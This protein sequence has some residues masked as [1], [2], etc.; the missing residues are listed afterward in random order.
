MM[1][2]RKGKK[3]EPPPQPEAAPLSKDEVKEKLRKRW[4]EWAEEIG[5]EHLSYGHVL[6]GTKIDSKSLYT[7][8]EGIEAYINGLRTDENGAYVKDFEDDIDWSTLSGLIDEA[9]SGSTP[10]LNL[11]FKVWKEEL[12]E[13][14]DEGGEE[15]SQ[16]EEGAQEKGESNF[17]ELGSR[18]LDKTHKKT[19]RV[20]CAKLHVDKY[21]TSLN[22]IKERAEK[23]FQG[24]Q[25]K[26]TFYKEGQEDEAYLEE[27]FASYQEE[28][29]KLV[30]LEDK[31]K[32]VLNTTSI[33]GFIMLDLGKEKELLPFKRLQ[34]SFK[35]VRNSVLGLNRKKSIK[36][37]EEVSYHIPIALRKL[38]R[39]G[40]E[41]EHL[42][43]L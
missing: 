14:N 6:L 40:E 27:V 22:S 33:E 1:F 8:D 7:Q 13:Y 35:Y 20:L 29:D 38:E 10:Q 5:M 17:Q 32:Q 21:N 12:G 9:I 31:R 37:R 24:L 28:A 3:S 36:P 42:M 34:D 18:E 19:Y 11:Y 2:W 4:E 39:V 26:V 25:E 41:A 16:E 15:G 23:L 43:H 30:N